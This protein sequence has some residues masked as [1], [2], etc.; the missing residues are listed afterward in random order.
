M[1]STHSLDVDLYCVTSGEVN[2]LPYVAEK[3][4]DIGRKARSEGVL[5][6]SNGHWGAKA[7]RTNRVR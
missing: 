6:G 3:W 7:E 2:G 5:V 1:G 4:V